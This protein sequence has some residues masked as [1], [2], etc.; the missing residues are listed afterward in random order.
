MTSR[1]HYEENQREKDTCIKRIKSVWIEHLEKVLKPV[2]KQQV[3]Y[4]Y[5]YFYIIVPGK[6]KVNCNKIIK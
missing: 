5:F 3:I 6:S 2:L 1:V 4:I